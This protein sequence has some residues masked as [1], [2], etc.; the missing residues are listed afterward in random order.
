M[1][2]VPGQ[3]GVC[4]SINVL[5]SSD[6]V[7]KPVEGVA[8]KFRNLRQRWDNRLVLERC[9]LAELYIN[10]RIEI[11]AYGDWAWG[12][13][14]YVWACRIKAEPAVDQLGASELGIDIVDATNGNGR[15]KIIVLVVVAE[16]MKLPKMFVRSV[17]RPYLIEKK[18]F[19]AGDGL[20]YRRETSGG[21]EVLP[22]G[23]KREMDF[24]WRGDP[25]S[26]DSSS[27]MIKCAPEVAK[28]I[29][30]D[31]CKHLWDVLFG[32]KGQFMMRRIQVNDRLAFQ[33]VG[34]LVQVPVERVG[35]LP[36]FV[37]VAVGPLN[38]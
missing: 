20:L 17:F 14:Q 6:H 9:S 4:S 24:R 12:R 23:T 22:F 1:R 8:D 19:R 21:Y 18:F 11:V 7:L 2:H 3:A 33:A 36:Q 28:R 5:F 32:P 16:G 29:A 38:L 30:D 37:N 13:N 15:D 35:S 27:K 25:G 34:N 10:G 26:D 31:A